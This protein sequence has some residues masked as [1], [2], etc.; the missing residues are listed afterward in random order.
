MGDV[1]ANPSKVSIPDS[2]ID[3]GLRK[4]HALHLVH[5]VSTPR[6]AGLLLTY[7]LRFDGE[8]QRYAIEALVDKV[9]A[10]KERHEYKA[11]KDR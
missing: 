8:F 5:S 11:W 2:S 4:S 10:V 1:L 6:D 3:H 7:F 9:P